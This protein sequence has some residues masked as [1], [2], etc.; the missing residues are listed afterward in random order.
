MKLRIKSDGT[1][2]GTCVV[3]ENGRDISSHITGVSF[4]HSAGGV[5]VANLELHLV[6]IEE[7]DGKVVMIGPDGKEVRRI[8]YADGSVDD[9]SADD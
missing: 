5:P 3:D 1:Q 8:E 9:Y 4:V 6:E 2:F 7:Y